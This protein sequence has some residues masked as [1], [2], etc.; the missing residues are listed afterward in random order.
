MCPSALKAITMVLAAL[1]ISACGDAKGSRNNSNPAVKQQTA[2]RNSSFSLSP[3]NFT[4]IEDSKLRQC[5]ENTGIQFTAQLQILEC[6]D[7]K[8]TSI[9][10]LEQFHSLSVLNLS[11]NQI[12]NI[13]SLGKATR[14]A[15]VNL[16][17][18]RIKSIDAL[19]ALPNLRELSIA[20]N[21]LNNLEQIP[22]FSSLQKLYAEHNQIQSLEP[23]ATSG[24]VFLVAHNNPAPLP[25]SLSKKI[26]SFR[27]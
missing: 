24:V 8:I 16:T 7:S 5:I 9:N 4:L 27:I 25:S 12:S 2:T 11:N 14:L 17:R 22:N 1:F 13:D 3:I 6:T 15:S 23:I 10:G 19:A 20:H 26:Q 18:N 21:H